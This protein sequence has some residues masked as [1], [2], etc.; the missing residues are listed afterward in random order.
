ML[1]QGTTKNMQAVSP[2]HIDRM[3]NSMQVKSSMFGLYSLKTFK[4]Y[5]VNSFKLWQKLLN[6]CVIIMSWLP[7]YPQTWF[8]GRKICNAFA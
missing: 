6:V 8:P 2:L 4:K 1:V 3:I 5:C 7:L